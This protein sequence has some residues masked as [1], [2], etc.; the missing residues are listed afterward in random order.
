MVKVYGG[1]RKEPDWEKNP[2]KTYLAV[3]VADLQI[4]VV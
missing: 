4:S 3:D 2:K 1:L